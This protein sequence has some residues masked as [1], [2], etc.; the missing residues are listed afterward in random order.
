M[1]HGGLVQVSRTSVQESNL[2]VPVV[3][4][5]DPGGRCLG[6]PGRASASLPTG[7]GPGKSN[8]AWLSAGSNG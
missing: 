4:L 2:S 6:G 8:Q 7:E 1:G 5:L 3:L